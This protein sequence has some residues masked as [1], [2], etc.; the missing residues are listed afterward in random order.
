MALLHPILQKNYDCWEA[1]EAEL[2]RVQS[3]SE[4]GD[5]FEQFIYFYLLYHSDYY[6]IREIYS[7]K[8][9]GREIPK[10]IKDQLKLEQNDYGVDGVYITNDSIM[11]AYQVKF[12][13]GGTPPDARELS[14]FWAEGEYADLRC[15][16]ANSYRLPPVSEKKKNHLAILRD[17]FEKLTPEFFLALSKFAASGTTQKSVK[18]R[19]RPYQEKML[20]GIMDG[21]T[22]TDRGKLIA[23]CGTGKT[24]ISLWV[25]EYLDSSTVLFLAP[26]LILIRQ[27]LEQW[28]KNS[29]TPFSYLCVCSDSSISTALEGDDDALELHT[30]D[31]DFPI[32]TDSS[33]VRKY[34]NA[35]TGRKKV[36]FATYHS[37]GVIKEAFEKE[38]SDFKF[39]LTI[40]DEAHRTA[41]ARDL[42]FFS[43]ALNEDAIPTK[44]KLFMTATERLVMPWIR[45]RVEQAGQIVFSMDDE[46]VYGPVFY[47]M[48]F[49][50]AIKEGVISDYR[51]VLAGIT[52]NHFHE[53]VKSNRYLSV[54]S[55]DGAEA[56]PAQ[57]LF[58]AIL[59]LKIMGD[60]KANKLISYHSSIK[61]AKLFTERLAILS[62]ESKQQSEDFESTIFENINGGQ[63]SAERSEIFHAFEKS[64]RGVLSNVRCLTEG[65]DLPYIDGV[66]FTT[67][68]NSIIDIV[69][70]VG[71]ALRQPYGEKKKTAYIILPVILPEGDDGV[72]FEDEQFDPLHK[73]IEALREQDETLAE[74]INELNLSLVQGK[75]RK[76]K[77][78]K[79]KLKIVL[80]EGIDIEHFET[81][82]V[83]RIAEVCRHPVSVRGEAGRLGKTERKSEFKRQFKCIGDYNADIYKDSLVDPTLER[84]GLDTE[85]VSRD[86]IKIN[87]N[88]VSHTERLGLIFQHEKNKFALT[89]LGRAYR[90]GK[91]TFINLF[92]NQ[93]LLYGT[94]ADGIML[95]PYR[96]AF[97][98]MA[99]VGTL[100]YIEFL[101]GIYSMMPTQ[102]GSGVEE[103]IKRILWIRKNYPNA[104]LTGAANRD[105][106]REAL[107]ENHPVGFSHKDLW[108]DRTTSGNQYRYFLNH[109][110]LFD[111]IYSFDWDDK[112]LKVIDSEK[113]KI[114][115][116]LAASVPPS[117][118]YREYYGYWI[119]YGKIKS[120]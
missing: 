92:K 104:Q 89:K 110:S 65:V 94:E 7:P 62:K 42:S 68:K 60:L 79:G 90:D 47:K 120:A 63:A 75:A 109:M 20:E 59:T 115:Q 55:D 35:K 82:I 111:D 2:E 114:D 64:S 71:R 73:L 1:L 15:I 81:S 97:E 53:L 24:M 12:R 67:P 23:A 88:N 101:Y 50:K 119:W 5:V 9:V 58:K 100:N 113:S 66:L 70:A 102:S 93:M 25:S 41:G 3:A 86:T 98:I 44:K 10:K 17:R 29:N 95:Y 91:I 87:N 69:Q 48:S 22:R 14:M 72:S 26:S 74:W 117:N 77:M 4:K 116:I 108:T 56:I 52:E 85:N 83:V 61:R 28:A 19:P 30:E 46:N 76:D 36:I 45:D 103:T 106:V 54:A 99:G 33:T 18:A 38:E 49:G 34:V 84:F 32:T 13:T 8:V 11:A 78:G 105:S 51:L 16:I 21:F 40:F 31:I 6:Q 112:V 80:P 37:A 43:V 118:H 96:S 39:D 27:T 57:D 107:N